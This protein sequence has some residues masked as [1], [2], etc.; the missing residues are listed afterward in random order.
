MLCLGLAAMF[1]GQASAA[2]LCSALPIHPD[3]LSVANVTFNGSNADDCYGVA[4][5]NDT[6][7]NMGFSGFQALVRDD[8]PGSGTS[9]GAANGVTFTLGAEAGT[10]GNWTLSWAG[11]LPMTMDLVA[12]IGGGRMFASYFFDNLEFTADP[13]SAGG[14][15]VIKFLDAANEA[16]PDLNHLSLYWSD[17]KPG[18]GPCCT[19]PVEEPDSLAILALAGLTLAL[20]SRRRPKVRRF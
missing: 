1:G 20:I 2:L 17:F 13:A 12:V 16:I 18:G 3:G 5:G 4:A 6:A 8:T 15:F 11:T 19:S 10:S 9:S 14:T 7:A